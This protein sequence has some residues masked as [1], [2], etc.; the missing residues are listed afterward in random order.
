MVRMTRGRAWIGVLGVLLA[1]IVALNVFTLSFAATAGHDRPERS[2][3]SNR[4]TRSCAAAT[5]SAPAPARDPPRRR[6]ARAGDAAADE[7]DFDRAEPATTSPS[8]AQRLA[9]AGTGY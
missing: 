2:S 1:G 5:R 7:V 9:A 3:P 6:R 4:R 8:P